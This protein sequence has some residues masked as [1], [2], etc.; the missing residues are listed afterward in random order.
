MA[1]P[2]SLTRV[3]DYQDQPTG[4][5]QWHGTLRDL[6]FRSLKI[7]RSNGQGS[8]WVVSDSWTDLRLEF[9]TLKEVCV[10][11]G[12]RRTSCSRD[13]QRQRVYTA[14]NVVVDR[15]T[16]KTHDEVVAFVREVEDSPLLRSWLSICRRVNVQT[17]RKGVTKSSANY[18]SWTIWIASTPFHRSKHVVLHELAHLVT[19]ELFKGV[20]AHGAEFCGVLMQLTREF[21][22]YNVAD[23]LELSFKDHN[24]KYDEHVIAR[25][26]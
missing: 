1:G 13:S 8:P 5:Y 4:V 15:G 16:F 11:I 17:A 23:K 26:K 2:A 3:L 21:R 7:C 10:W 24:V 22:G 6:G 20:A 25:I 19:G 9:S 18:S 14:E 12:E